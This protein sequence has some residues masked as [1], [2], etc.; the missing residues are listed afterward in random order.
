MYIYI[1]L[2]HVESSPGI[3]RSSQI[4]TFMSA[5]KNSLSASFHPRLFLLGQMITPYLYPSFYHIMTF[6]ILAGSGHWDFC[7]FPLPRELKFHAL[8]SAYRFPT[9]RSSRNLQV[10]VVLLLRSLIFVVRYLCGDYLVNNSFHHCLL[11]IVFNK[12]F[13]NW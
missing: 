8:S 6:F 5:I 7:C 4:S 1:F 12:Y 11:Y 10:I 2:H 9:E 3:L 13:I